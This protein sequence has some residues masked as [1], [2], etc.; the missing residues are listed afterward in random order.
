MTEYGL[1][2]PVHSPHL[3]TRIR[4]RRLPPD[5]PDR[6]F[7]EAQERFFDTATGHKI[8]VMKIPLQGKLREIMLAYEEKKGKVVLITIHP[9]KK[10][11]KENRIQTG[12]WKRL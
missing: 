12:R 4:L 1:M 6:I 8:A 2:K 11:Q 5:L 9:L 7:T 3:K 10:R